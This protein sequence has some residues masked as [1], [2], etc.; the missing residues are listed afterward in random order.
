MSWPF[1]ARG[2]SGGERP[3]V[4]RVSVPLACVRDQV[5]VDQIGDHRARAPWYDDVYD[6]TGDYD[7]GPEL[8]GQW[9]A[10]LARSRSGALTGIPSR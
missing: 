10:D 4:A 1:N 5:A 2:H 6:C 3:K 7:R 9:L 8:N